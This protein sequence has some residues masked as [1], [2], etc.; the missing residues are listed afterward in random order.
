MKLKPPP[1]GESESTNKWPEFCGELTSCLLSPAP[2]IPTGPELGDVLGL[3]GAPCWKG[4]RGR[5]TPLQAPPSSS[6]ARTCRQQPF[7]GGR[8]GGKDTFRNQ[9]TGNKEAGAL[10]EDSE[11]CPVKCDGTAS[12]QLL[13]KWRQRGKLRVLPRARDPNPEPRHSR[14]LEIVTSSRSRSCR[15]R[16]PEAAAGRGQD[17]G[18]GPGQRGKLHPYPCPPR[19]WQRTVHPAGRGLCL[20][21]VG[22][23]FC[24]CHTT[25]LFQACGALTRPPADRSSLLSVRP[26]QRTEGSSLRGGQSKGLQ[27]SRS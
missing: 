22:P 11:D 16:C 13:R 14:T 26:P 9:K 3:Q 1:A 5:S 24:P 10:V 18:G 17:G 19:T 15:S 20:W 8:A 12:F 4:G 7:V 25:C 6:R 2:A 27:P 21:P 23:C